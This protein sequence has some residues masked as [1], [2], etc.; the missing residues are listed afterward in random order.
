[1][2]KRIVA[3]CYP[4]LF[5]SLVSLSLLTA[6]Y[7]RNDEQQ[8]FTFG[9]EWTS[10]RDL[11][12]LAKFDIVEIEGT[13]NGYTITTGYSWFSDSQSIG[14]GVGIVFTPLPC[15]NFELDYLGGKEPYTNVS[16]QF[17]LVEPSLRFQFYHRL[18][19]DLYFL[20]GMGLSYYDVK[21]KADMYSTEETLQS[22][23]RTDFQGGGGIGFRYPILRHLFLTIDYRLMVGMT[24]GGGQY[25]LWIN[26]VNTGSSGG[27]SHYS[28]L[29]SIGVR[30]MF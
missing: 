5:L 30:Y 8:G 28:K 24:E 18:K 21:M 19:C 11:F 26:G 7:S 10:C 9:I 14:W 16:Y 15:K 3:I 27:E 20:F 29:L 22:T 17:I 4:Q 6:Q 23:Y 25:D 13:F 12:V 2:K 1:M